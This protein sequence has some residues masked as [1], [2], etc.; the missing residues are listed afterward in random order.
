LL[1][2]NPQAWSWGFSLS[3]EKTK[4]MKH[5]ISLLISVGFMLSVNGQP[6]QEQVNTLLD[7]WHR[8]A[9]EANGEVFF[10]LMAE[11]SLYIGTDSWERWT[12]PEFYAFAKP[13]FARGK[14]WDFTP[15]DRRIDFSKDGKTLWFSELLDTWMGTCRGSGV[16]IKDKKEW[17]LVQY[18]LSVTVPNERI[19]EFIG[20]FYPPDK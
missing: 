16:M 20:T 2:E 13:Y 8:A 11:N 14:A 4:S 10:G 17:K 15:R 18:H 1:S 19:Q 12:K 3:F 6:P 9:A 7:N 5:L